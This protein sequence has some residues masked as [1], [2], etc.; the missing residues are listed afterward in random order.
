MLLLVKAAGVAVVPVSV[1]AGSR[2]TETQSSGPD[3]AEADIL[4]SHCVSAA[5][6]AAPASIVDCSMTVGVSVSSS[7][8]PLGTT[9]VSI[10]VRPALTTV[11]SVPTGGGGASLVGEAGSAWATSSAHA[12]SAA[13]GACSRAICL[14]LATEGDRGQ[15][16]QG[17][18]TIERQGIV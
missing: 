11:G 12:S 15:C 9:G 13:Y 8:P 1:S 7:A 16:L 10:S 18:S 3:S 4:A 14:T 6:L 2:G 17:I 5:A